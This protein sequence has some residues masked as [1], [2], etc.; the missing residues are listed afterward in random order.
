MPEPASVWQ[1]IKNS[2]ALFAVFGEDGRLLTAS[3]GLVAATGHTLKDLRGYPPDIRNAILGLPA[4]DKFVATSNEQGA[5][6]TT[7]WLRRVDGT[8]SRFLLTVTPTVAR[9]AVGRHFVI[10]AIDTS[11]DPGLYDRPEQ[12]VY[13]DRLTGLHNRR[14]LKD[15]INHLEET[16]VSLALLIVDLVDFGEINETF[17]HEA[18]DDVLCKVGGIL[19]ELAPPGGTTARLC[20]D[21]FALLLGGI[22]PGRDAEDLAD[23]ILTAISRP[24]S[25]HDETVRVTG[26]AGISRFPEDGRDLGE[27]LRRAGAKMRGSGRKTATDAPDAS[28]PSPGF[29]TA[30]KLVRALTLEALEEGLRPY[31]QPIVDMRTRRIVGAEALCRWL[32]CDGGTVLPREFIPVAETSG[33]IAELDRKMFEMTLRGM[34]AWELSG[35]PDVQ[36]SINVAAATLRGQGFS[37]FLEETVAAYGIRHEQICIELTESMALHEADPGRDRVFELRELGFHVAL[38][39]FGTGYSSLALLKSLPVSRLKVDRSFI[40]NLA[41]NPRDRGIVRSIADIS[42]ALGAE[43]VA[44][45]VETAEQVTLLSEYGY[46]LGQ[47][48]LFARPMPSGE[49]TAWL[50][51]PPPVAACA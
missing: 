6:R 40:L 45:G 22:E 8:A 19:T 23:E 14:F 48:F 49:F 30:P 18:G 1:T 41:A 11:G 28:S 9:G 43:T 16:G 37:L 12:Q 26:L 3:L 47:G 32:H 29:A 24:M 50:R 35:L 51:N 44:E 31:F 36:I 10:Q 4:W 38:D 42:T 15:T 17:G 5:F 7:S 2:D 20:S 34:R 39:D 27:L 21:K 13:R 33:L 25:V 46:R